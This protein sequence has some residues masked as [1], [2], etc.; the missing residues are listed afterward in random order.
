[1]WPDLS[2]YFP[3]KQNLNKKKKCLVLIIKY[4]KLNKNEVR[5]VCAKQNTFLDH[6]GLPGH[7]SAV[8]GL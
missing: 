5:Q 2:L 4:W 3:K 6:A 8:L 1:M 7:G